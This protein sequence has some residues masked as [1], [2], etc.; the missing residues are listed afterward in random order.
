MSVLTLLFLLLFSPTLLA[1]VYELPPEGQH[2]VGEGF[3]VIARHEDTL[4]DIAARHGIGYD[5]IKAANPEVDPWL[6]GERTR[7]FIPAEFVLP[8]EPRQGMVINLAEKR[9]YY[10]PRPAANERPKLHTY[11]ISIGRQNWETPL[12]QTRIVRKRKDPTW[13]PPESIREEHAA[14]G[15]ILPDVV[16]AGPDNPLG[17]RAMYLGIPGYLIHG[18]NKPAGIG[19]RVSHGCIRMEPDN[20]RELFELVPANTPVKLIDVPFKF[21]IRQGLIYLEAQQPANSSIHMHQDR[22][23]LTGLLLEATGGE[24]DFELDWDR[25]DQAI[26]NPRGIP[27]PVGSLSS[28]GVGVGVGVGPQ[29][30]TGLF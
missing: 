10:Y 19:M 22:E 26:K 8:A 15:D 29:T 1:A 7:V 14:K 4:V 30:E 25:L 2:L 13:T 21:G 28:V 3:F 24:F 18:T 16:P 12:G 9:I 27:L 20:I 17:D 11:P 5:E 6:P 23:Q